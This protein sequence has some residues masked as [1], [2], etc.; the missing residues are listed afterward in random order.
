MKYE[1]NILPETDLDIENIIIFLNRQFVWKE[2]LF[3]LRDVLYSKI[4]SLEFYPEIFP[5]IYNDYRRALVKNYSIFYK[6]DNIKK[7]VT[8]YRV[9]HQAQNFEEYLD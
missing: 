7:E 8:I 1:V 3:R 5:E 6:V 9:L 2:T 4:Y